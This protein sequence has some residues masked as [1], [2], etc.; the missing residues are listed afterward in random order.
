MNDDLDHIMTVM[1]A[2]FDPRWGEAWSHRQV[3]DLLTLPS[4]HYRLVDRDGGPLTDGGAPA[5]FILTR[6]AADQEELL[7]VA[8]RPECRGRGIGRRLLELFKNDARLRGAAHVF[9]EMRHNNPAAALYRTA[10][11]VPL[12]RR[13]DYYRLKDGGRLDAITYG[14]NLVQN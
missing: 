4:T 1:E 13:P 10:G 2:A 6:H 7:L 9:L 11:F 3:A 14:C 8:V 12:G 5:G